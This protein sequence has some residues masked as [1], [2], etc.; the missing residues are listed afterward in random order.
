MN[1]QPVYKELNCVEKSMQGTE[2][3]VT[4]NSSNES[5]TIFSGFN[6]VMT[7]SHSKLL[8]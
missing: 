3:M 7:H 5:E 4:L 1:P 6:A 2:L 8:W